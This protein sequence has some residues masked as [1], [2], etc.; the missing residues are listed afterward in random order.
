M[1]SLVATVLLYLPCQL[2]TKLM[3]LYKHDS[4]GQRQRKSCNVVVQYSGH[5]TE[6]VNVPTIE[7]ANVV[8]P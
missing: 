7:T 5:A 8:V 3:V 4:N 2:A 6:L 1:A